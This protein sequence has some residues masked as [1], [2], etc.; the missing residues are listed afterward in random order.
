MWTRSLYLTFNETLFGVKP[1]LARVSVSPI[2]GISTSQQDNGFLFNVIPDRLLGHKTIK[3]E[4]NT[5]SLFSSWVFV[6][7]FEMKRVLFTYFSHLLLTRHATRAAHPECDLHTSQDQNFL[8][9]ISELIQDCFNNQSQ[10]TLLIKEHYKKETWLHYQQSAL[11]PIASSLN[12]KQLTKDPIVCFRNRSWAD[13][14]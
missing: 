6:K 12:K 9:V 10:N 13:S 11:A 4:K 5:T 7:I 1:L 2:L 3:F 8:N 14:W